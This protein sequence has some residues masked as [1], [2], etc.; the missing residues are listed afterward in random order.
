MRRKPEGSFRTP[1]C[2]KGGS[3]Y[4]LARQGGFDLSGVNGRIISEDIDGIK[5]VNRVYMPLS[6]EQH[7]KDRHIP[8][9]SSLGKPLP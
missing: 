8:I 6:T 7:F 3:N 1:T 2:W 5:R 9:K 4:S